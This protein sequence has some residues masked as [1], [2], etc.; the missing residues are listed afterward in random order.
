MKLTSIWQQPRFG[1]KAWAHSSVD[2]QFEFS[3]FIVK[4]VEKAP[5]S[6]LGLARQQHRHMKRWRGR[7]AGLTCSVDYRAA[8]AEFD[9]VA[10][11]FGTRAAGLR[12]NGNKNRISIIVWSNYCCGREQC[13]PSWAWYLSSF[14]SSCSDS[15]APYINNM[16]QVCGGGPLHKEYITTKRLPVEDGFPLCTLSIYDEYSRRITTWQVQRQSCTNAHRAQLYAR[17]THFTGVGYAADKIGLIRA[18][19]YHVSIWSRMSKL[20]N[21]VWYCCMGNRL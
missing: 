12:K 18:H 10:L 21:N 5:L 8:W 14:V 13:L 17:C 19:N 4:C 15:L 11:L 7:R 20:S 2:N 3:R 9:S 6:T 16:Y 1:K